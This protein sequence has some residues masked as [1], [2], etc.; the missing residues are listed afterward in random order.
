MSELANADSVFLLLLIAVCLV[1]MVSPSPTFLPSDR[2]FRA[3]ERA[4]ESATSICKKCPFHA[5]SH[6]SARERPIEVKASF[7]GRL[8]CVDPLYLNTGGL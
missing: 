1:V 6:A 7:G 3:C 4:Q 8:I 5:S 2:A